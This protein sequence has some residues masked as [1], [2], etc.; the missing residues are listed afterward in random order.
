MLIRTDAL[1]NF[2]EFAKQMF[3]GTTRN[4]T[5]PMDSWRD[6]DTVFAEFDLPGVTSDSIDIDVER[7]VLTV[8][9]NR[10]QRTVSG[11]VLMNERHRGTF[12]R[13]LILGDALDTERIEAK[14]ADGVLAVAIPVAEKAK[15]RKVS[16][17]VN[18]SESEPEV[19]RAESSTPTL[20][21]A[22][23]TA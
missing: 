8:T 14:Y 18:S 2:D 3:G 15:P 16:V 7:N 13:Q 21:T 11:K 12:S 5:I 4:T 20:A 1:N 19:N 10:P 23:A 17:Q 6:G 22:G 9:A